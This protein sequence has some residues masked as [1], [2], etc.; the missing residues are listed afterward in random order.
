M[1]LSSELTRITPNLKA[2]GVEATKLPRTA[3]KR[4]WDIRKA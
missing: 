1:S 2:E 3:K 4:G